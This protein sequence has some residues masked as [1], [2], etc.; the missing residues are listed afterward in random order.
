M[1]ISARLAAL[2]G[3]G[4]PNAYFPAVWFVED[5]STVQDELR[6]EYRGNGNV[7]PYRWND[8]FSD[9][10][11]ERLVREKWEAIEAAQERDREDRAADEVAHE[12]DGQQAAD[13]NPIK[14]SDPDHIG[15]SAELVM[16]QPGNDQG[17]IDGSDAAGQ[18][19]AA[20]EA[21]ELEDQKRRQNSDIAL[22]LALLEA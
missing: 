21:A 10:D 13:Q 17:L 7:L 20:A 8:P 19:S 1:T 22:I 18:L 2:F 9:A 4:G 11:I 5:E 15:D 14:N 16:P 6:P 3:Y 12:Q